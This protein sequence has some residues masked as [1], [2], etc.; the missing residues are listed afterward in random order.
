MIKSIF[1][2][3]TIAG[4]TLGGTLF[5]TNSQTEQQS[6]NT[7]VTKE[8]T[9]TYDIKNMTCKMCPITVRRAMKQVNGVV[10]ASSDFDNKTATVIFDPTKTNAT[11]VAEAS[12][13]AGYPATAQNQ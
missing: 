3:L 1:V 6:Q 4:I 5:A 12:T 10:S 8:Q 11:E 7:N 2:I 9:V 13:N